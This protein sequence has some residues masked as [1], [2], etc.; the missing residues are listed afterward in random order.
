MCWKCISVAVFILLPNISF[1]AETDL[2]AYVSSKGKECSLSHDELNAQVNSQLDFFADQIRDELTQRGSSATEVSASHQQV[3]IGL[4]PKVNGIDFWV[5]NNI[6]VKIG[7]FGFSLRT[8]LAPTEAAPVVK[9]GLWFP[10]VVSDTGKGKTCKLEP[11]RVDPDQ[12]K[13]LPVVD[14]VIGDP[15]R[16]IVR[17]LV[18]VANI[19]GQPPSVKAPDAVPVPE[20]KPNSRDEIETNAEEE[21]SEARANRREQ[22]EERRERNRERK[23]RRHREREH[24]HRYRRHYRHVESP[25]TADPPETTDECSLPNKSAWRAFICAAEGK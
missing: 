18:Q 14:L 8:T 2:S 19:N 1:A 9:Q 15:A 16:V 17:D 10:L 4:F 7:K 20:Q 22:R 11:I 25:T 23:H 6:V 13:F 12:K 24:R 5:N 21:N 3:D